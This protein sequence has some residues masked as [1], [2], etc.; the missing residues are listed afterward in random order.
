[1]KYNSNNKLK[2]KNKKNKIKNCKMLYQ[3]LIIIYLILKNK[4]I[5][6]KLSYKICI[7]NKLKIN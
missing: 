6:T 3:I 5:K 1:M 4:L 7:N 2:N